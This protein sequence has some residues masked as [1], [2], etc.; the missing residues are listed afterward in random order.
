VYPINNALR[1]K[2]EMEA[3]AIQNLINEYLYK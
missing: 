2:L 3:I 1:V